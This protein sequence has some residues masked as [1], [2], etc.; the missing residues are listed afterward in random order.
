M[1]GTIHCIVL[2]YFRSARDGDFEDEIVPKL[3]FYEEVD[4]SLKVESARFAEGVRTKCAPVVFKRCPGI[5]WFAAC[6]FQSL[7]VRR[8]RVLLVTRGWVK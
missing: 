3:T 4:D 1:L 6:V 7:C 2:I 8:H 5:S